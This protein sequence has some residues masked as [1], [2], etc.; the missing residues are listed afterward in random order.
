MTTWITSDWHIRHRNI[1]KYCGRP[2]DYDEKIMAGLSVVKYNDT[3]IHCGDFG[4]INTWDEV[5]EVFDLIPCQNRILI[6]GNHD[7]RSKHIHRLPWSWKVRSN[8]QPYQIEYNGLIIA[9]QHK[10]Y[11]SEQR[12]ST[13]RRWLIQKWFSFAMRG[14]NGLP[15]QANIAI[16]GHVHELGQRYQWADNKLVVNAC[17]EHWDYKP[18]S[19]SE[20]VKEYHARKEYEKQVTWRI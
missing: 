18:V 20:L 7:K 15:S 6:V 8:D 4:F 16:H 10:P 5:K 1:I 9:L 12:R 11:L 13:L 14:P 17:V 3:L 19:L 2:T